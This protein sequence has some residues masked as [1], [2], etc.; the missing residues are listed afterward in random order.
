MFGTKQV[1][2]IHGYILTAWASAGIA[3]PM[4]VSWI[5]EM[6]SGYTSTLYVFAGLF[7]VAFVVSL[8]IKKN[9]NAV[10]AELRA[11]PV[12]VS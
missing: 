7:V 2:A 6:T 10:E 5:R 8:L 3:G 4:F 12:R 11:V 9:I 1:S